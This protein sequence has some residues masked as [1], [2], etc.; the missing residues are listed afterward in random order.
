ME[1][2]TILAGFPGGDGP[3]WHLWGLFQEEKS[4]LPGDYC[5]ESPASPQKPSSVE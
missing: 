5:L 2:V 3:A 1:E 4:G